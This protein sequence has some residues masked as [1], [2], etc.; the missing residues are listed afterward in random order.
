MLFYL[1]AGALVK[2]Y[3]AEVGSD[4]V[5]AITSQ[6]TAGATSILSR[7]ET[8]AALAKAVRVG[9]SAR[10]EAA[11]AVQVFRSEWVNFVRIQATEVVIA[12]ADQVAW[13]FG[14]RGY[15]AVHLASALLWR[16][17]MNEAVVFAS[18]DRQ[19]WQAAT[20]SGLLPFPEERP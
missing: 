10:E 4:A 5:A 9:T 18:F 16:E 17:N 2:R 6:A 7:V 20:D 13:R 15:D 12:R 11:A 3:V 19:L 1:D 14:L 8:V